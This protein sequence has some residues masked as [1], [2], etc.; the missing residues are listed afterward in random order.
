MLV[1]H[2][3][4]DDA[5]ILSAMQYWADNIAESLQDDAGLDVEIDQ[6]MIVVVTA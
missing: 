3:G 4:V 6:N 2:E 5:E 1:K